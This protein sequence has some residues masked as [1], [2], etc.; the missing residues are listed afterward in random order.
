MRQDFDRSVPLIEQRMR[1][2]AAK[3]PGRKHQHRPGIRA[4]E[5]K[6]LAAK[7]HAASMARKKAQFKALVAAYWRGERETYPQGRR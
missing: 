2:A 4:N 1:V 6:K 7:R 5:R 3:E